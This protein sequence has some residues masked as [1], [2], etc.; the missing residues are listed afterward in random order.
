MHLVGANLLNAVQISKWRKS[1]H[2][3]QI[4]MTADSLFDK[5]PEG[6]M[7]HFGNCYVRT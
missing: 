4:Y 1:P 2:I 3:S 6:T 5:L 7:F